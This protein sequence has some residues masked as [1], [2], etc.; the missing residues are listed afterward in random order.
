M[1]E[2]YL[3]Y[4]AKD[5]L[6]NKDFKAWITQKEHQQDWVKWLQQ[7][8]DKRVEVLKALEQVEKSKSKAVSALRM[9]ELRAM[10]QPP[11]PQALATPRT[12]RDNTR[13]QT[14]LDLP[15]T[16]R[17]VNPIKQWL[18]YVAVACLALPLM[19]FFLSAKQ[20]HHKTV[21][22]DR[23]EKHPNFTLPDGSIVQLN[24]D[25]KLTYDPET[26][27]A[28]R[29][30]HLEG[31]AFFEIKEGS[32]FTVTTD[33]GE[34]ELPTA[35]V[36]VHARDEDLEVSCFRGDVR[37]KHHST[38]EEMQLKAQEQVALEGNS[39]EKKLFDMR[40]H[41]TWRK[42]SFYYK[43]Q[44]VGTI[45]DEIERQY[46]VY[47]KAPKSLEG[48]AVDFFFDMREPLDNTVQNIGRTL[49]VE[50]EIKE[51]TI[52]LSEAR[53]LGEKLM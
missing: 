52:I 30:V 48:Q 34:V 39:L 7:H 38:G 36:N 11:Q 41:A 40:S 14:P 1:K 2:G 12:R 37:V 21:V 15:E 51:D 17:K 3:H 45:L 13:V 16:T 44:S 28:A 35:I 43:E 31:E 46:N 24:A 5:F 25:S 8:P 23:G 9:Q 22:A 4:T 49:N 19:F 47:I 20:Q 33:K 10:V 6:Q 50:V 53:V 42:G 32:T 29:T 26:W 27:D 18:P